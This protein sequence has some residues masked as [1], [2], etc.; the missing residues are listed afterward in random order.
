MKNP[1]PTRSIKHEAKR[2]NMI[3][4]QI[5]H[6]AYDLFIQHGIKGVSMDDV[7][8]SAGVSK[9]TLYESFEDKEA[10]LAA[11][12]EQK[13]QDYTQRLAKIE[14]GHFNALEIILLFY[15][16]VIGNLNRH[17]EKFYTDLKKYPKVLE[18]I[19]QNG[20]LADE[21]GFA[22]LNKGVKEELFLKNVNLKLITTLEKECLKM[23]QTSHAFEEFSIT[24]VFSTTLLTFLKGICTEKGRIIIDRFERRR[25]LLS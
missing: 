1:T 25:S 15:E 21:K 4:S 20:K 22:L 5:V 11:G 17:N 2:Y 3:K 23:L 6:I 10:L 12:I 19:E 18:Q 13:F 8:K 9:R 24:E 16:D 14:K 7:A